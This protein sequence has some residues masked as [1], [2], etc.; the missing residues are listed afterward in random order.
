M[1]ADFAS[2]LREHGFA[3]DTDFYDITLAFYHEI[4]NLHQPEGDQALLY[5]SMRVEQQPENWDSLIFSEV[6]C[7]PTTSLDLGI[8]AMLHHWL[9]QLRY[10]RP[11]Y[12]NIEVIKKDRS[13]TISCITIACGIACTFTFVV[14][15]H[16]DFVVREEASQELTLGQL[17]HMLETMD[18]TF[19]G[20]LEDL[21]E[22]IIP[23]APAYDKDS[24]G[25]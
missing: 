8:E 23:A 17:D 25:K 13:A 20:P 24:R 1:P 11:D 16:P 9:S 12:E 18:A 3:P 19:D 6:S 2:K 15:Q 4:Y 10:Q 5:E 7:S 22:K 14:R 21:M